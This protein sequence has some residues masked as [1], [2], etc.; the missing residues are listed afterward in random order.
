MMDEEHDYVTVDKDSII[1]CTWCGSIESKAWKRGGT[2]GKPSGFYCSEDCFLAGHVELLRRSSRLFPCMGVFGLL[3]AFFDIYIFLTA[4]IFSF[5]LS[6]WLS[7][8]CRRNSLKGIEIRKK[9]PKGSRSDDRSLD[10]VVLERTQISAACPKCGANLDL[11]EIG[12]ERIFTCGYCGAE[13]ILEWP[14][15]DEDAPEEE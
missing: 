9:L 8:K 6:L 2:K 3:I 10:L 7:A 4:G 13:G 14:H 12:P 11:A 1:R 5:S 15:D